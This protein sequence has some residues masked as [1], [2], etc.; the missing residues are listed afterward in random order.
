MEMLCSE[1]GTELSSSA[2]RTKQDLS[3]FQA[4]IF[5]FLQVCV[6]NALEI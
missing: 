2:G 1:Q 5:F 4:H 3:V 6:I